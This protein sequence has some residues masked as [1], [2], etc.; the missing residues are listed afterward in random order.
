MTV[1]ASV[2]AVPLAY[3]DDPEVVHQYAKTLLELKKFWKKAWVKIYMSEFTAEVLEKEGLYQLR[4]TLNTLFKRCGITEYTVNDVVQVVQFF[5]SLRPYCEEVFGVSEVLAEK[6][7]LTPNLSSMVASKNLASNLE[8]CVILMAILRKYCNPPVTDHW[9]VV[10]KLVPT[11]PVEEVIVTA[12]IHDLE[13]KIQGIP[14]FPTY[15]DGSV[16]V[17]VGPSFSDLIKWLDEK[18]LLNSAAPQGTMERAIEIAIYKL[19]LKHLSQKRQI[20]IDEI[21]DER[22]KF[23]KFTFGKHFLATVQECCRNR[24]DLAEKLLRA[25]IETLE[26]QELQDIH[27]LRTGKGGNDPQRKRGQDVAW[28]RDLDN[29]YHLHYWECE[30]GSVEFANVVPHNNFSIT[31]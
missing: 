21:E 10:K 19:C 8:R 20:E 17:L 25:I 22:E 31:E 12:L 15:L 23:R 6:V 18:T 26:K 27:W 13:P 28:R 14:V 11:S 1:D 30:K 9:L 4:P 7:T 5:L 3:T 24:S 16:S 2:I 29:E